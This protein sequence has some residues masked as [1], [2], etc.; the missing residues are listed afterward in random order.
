MDTGKVPNIET[1]QGESVFPA[2]AAFMDQNQI[3]L[4]LPVTHGAHEKIVLANLLKIAPYLIHI[5]FV[6]F[7]KLF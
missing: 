7:P 1:R 2:A 6:F 4:A 3:W 5:I